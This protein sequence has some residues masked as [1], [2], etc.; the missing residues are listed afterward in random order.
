MKKDIPNAIFPSKKWLRQDWLHLGFLFSISIILLL[1]GLSVRSLWG[2][3]G[4]WAEIAREMIMSGN[5]FLPTINGLVYFDKPLL[6]Y[7]AIIPFAI[8]GIVTETSVRMP[9]ALAGIGAVIITFLIGRRLFGNRIGFVSSLLLLTSAMFILWSR[10]ASAEMLNLFAIWL[11]FWLFISGANR[12]STIYV[13]LLYSICAVASFLKGPVAPAVVFFSIIFYSVLEAVILAR[14]NNFTSTAVKDALF[15]KFQ[16]IISWQGFFGALTGAAIFTVLML[17]PV[18]FTGSWSSAEL[19]W[20]ENVQRFLRPFDHIEPFYVYFKHIPVFFAPWTILMLSCFWSIKYWKKNMPGR[21]IIFITT[22]IFLFFTIS[23]SRRSYYILP[24]LPG[25]ALITGKSLIDWLS[26]NNESRQRT[27]R[28]AAISTCFILLLF[29]LGIIY[30]YFDK[31]FPSHFS[32]LAIGFFALIGGIIS[33]VLFHKN[34]PEKGLA[35]LISIVFIVELWGFTI[36]M[37]LAEKKRTLRPFAFKVANYVK[38][39]SD[40]KISL[41]QGYDS[42]FVFYLKRGPLR[43]LNTA[44]EIKLFKKTHTDGFLVANMSSILKFQQEGSL[45]GISVIITE[46]DHTGKHKDNLAL[47]SFRN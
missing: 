21:L 36:G 23:G 10:T 25:L 3:E 24:I 29:G 19:M 1:T 46:K 14:K 8:N 6:S 16:W 2:S 20:K 27:I 26:G 42:A 43:R 28:F 47:F 4:R 39:V 31:S 45:D 38:N 13:I 7:W 17:I 11:S 9:G 35:I 34:I 12:G 44:E 32:Q 18:I 15:S 40:D 33:I 5:Y 30:V 37:T 22:A 41:F